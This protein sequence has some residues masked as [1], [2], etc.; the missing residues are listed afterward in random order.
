MKELKSVKKSI[1]KPVE[2]VQDKVFEVIKD[3]PELGLE[4]TKKVK[5]SVKPSVETLKARILEQN[6]E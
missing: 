5:N 4:V 3:R 6:K 1:K 2:N